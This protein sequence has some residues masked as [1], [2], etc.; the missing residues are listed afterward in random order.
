[1]I[2]IWSF[3][4]VLVANNINN[5]FLLWFNYGCKCKSSI[6]G[7]QIHFVIQARMCIIFY[8]VS[9]IS[10]FYFVVITPITLPTNCSP[11][12]HNCQMSNI[13]TLAN[14]ISTFLKKFV[15]K[16]PRMLYVFNLPLLLVIEHEMSKLWATYRHTKNVCHVQKFGDN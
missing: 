6:N 11:M 7:W 3:I 8:W 9:I 14:C 15:L 1:M 2:S 5:I 4:K 10:T 16:V 13:S 12:N